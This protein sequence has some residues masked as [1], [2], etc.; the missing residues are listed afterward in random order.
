MF[1]L[2]GASGGAGLIEFQRLDAGDGRPEVG[3]GCHKADDGRPEGFEVV[4]QIA[5]CDEHF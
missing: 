2:R 5:G 3:A 4:Q 1:V